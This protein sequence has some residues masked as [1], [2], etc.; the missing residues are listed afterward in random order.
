MTNEFIGW[1]TVSSKGQIS[2]PANIRRQLDIN[3]GDRLLIIKRK[4][5][6]GVN[7]IKESSVNKVFKK[8]SD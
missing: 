5:G 8:F 6:D 3:T 4:N 7:F 1:G 2:I